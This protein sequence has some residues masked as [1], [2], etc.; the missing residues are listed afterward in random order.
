MK[1]I[2]FESSARMHV[3]L[4][5]QQALRAQVIAGEQVAHE[6]AALREM[7]AKEQIR[8]QAEVQAW[9]RNLSE[10]TR[11]E[12]KAQEFEQRMLREALARAEARQIEA[13]SVVL[14]QDVQQR[15]RLLE[16]EFRQA[17]SE[18]P[19]ISESGSCCLCSKS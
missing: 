9:Q 15:F 14:T 10:T 6:M 17:K 12:L 11:V 3:G 5:E 8:Q 13:A 19:S 16:A 1:P 7:F 2:R 4:V 18:A